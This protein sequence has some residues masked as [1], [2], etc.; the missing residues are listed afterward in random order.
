MAGSGTRWFFTIDRFRVLVDAPVPLAWTHL[1]T[2]SATLVAVALGAT[3]WREPVQA[4]AHA[5]AGKG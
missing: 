4:H 2:S 1:S 5:D 3:A